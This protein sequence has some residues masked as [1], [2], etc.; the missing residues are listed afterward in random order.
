[1]TWKPQPRAGVDPF[2][3]PLDARQGYLLTL[4]DGA[5]GVAELALLT[6]QGEAEVRAALALLVGLGA[7]QP[8][9]GGAAAAAAAPEAP[10]EPE[11]EPEPQSDPEPEAEAAAT[12]HRERFETLLR[13]R[14]ADVRVALAK[15][16]E[17]PD[18]SAL[19]FDP[20]PE[21]VQ[22][23]L[24][25]PKFAPLQARLVAAHHRT[26]AGLEALG[27]RTAFAHDDGVRRA[28][29]RNPILPP[30]L[31]RRLWAN[32]R[33]HEQFLVATSKEAPEQTRIMAREV[34]RTTFTQRPGDERAELIVNTEG[35][36]LALLP[37][38]TLDGQAT[39]LLCR[40]TYSSTLFIQNLARWSA[41]PPQLVAHLRRQDLVKRN[42]V[43][44]Q[45]LE[46]HP[47]AS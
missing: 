21:V 23:L 38:A 25:N 41:C 8:E 20:L 47:N 35:R 12:T 4:A 31:F 32:R 37:A 29:L 19:C 42:P 46:R 39:A 5:H 30:A 22:A 11:A 6:G 7:L 27:G 9:E 26:S 2:A 44:R 33:L 17:E 40:R 3:L 16:A 36:C 43:L 15:T 14:G 45:M 1:M 18:L 34:L 13:G 10:P 24:E 28:L